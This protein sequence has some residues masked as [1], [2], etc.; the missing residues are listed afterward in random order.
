MN[1]ETAIT[2]A[3]RITDHFNDL[4]TF[5]TS[6]SRLALYPQFE[7]LATSEEL[8]SVELVFGS[9]DFNFRVSDCSEDDLS[10]G[11]WR[12]T[13]QLNSDS[14]YTKVSNFQLQRCND[15]DIPSIV[16]CTFSIPDEVKRGD[17]LGILHGDSSTLLHEQRAAPQLEVLLGEEENGHFSPSTGARQRGFPLISFEPS[18]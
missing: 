17:I 6:S 12:R 2:R 15:A 9:S 13:N 4:G 16:C 11:A 5:E 8:T 18:K 1:R 14:R 7:F 3:L 10:I